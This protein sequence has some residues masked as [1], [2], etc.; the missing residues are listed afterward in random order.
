MSYLF[1]FVSAK[2]IKRRRGGKKEVWF[3]FLS[4]ESLA[5]GKGGEGGPASG[6]ASLRPRFGP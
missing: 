3:Q 2:Q 4:R 6:A 5:V 1:P